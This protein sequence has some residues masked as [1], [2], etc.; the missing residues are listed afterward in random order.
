METDACFGLIELQRAV[1]Q[2]P[3]FLY[4]T[5]R[6]IVKARGCQFDLMAAQPAGEAVPDN[7]QAFLQEVVGVIDLRLGF[8]GQRGKLT[9][10][11]QGQVQ[12]LFKQAV[13]SAGTVENCPETAAANDQMA[14]GGKGAGF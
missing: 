4:M 11:R 13:E 5:R 14:H 7:Q 6:W 12:R 9:L 1:E 3:I 10:F 8:N 2:V